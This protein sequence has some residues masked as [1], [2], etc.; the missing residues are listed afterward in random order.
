MA[1]DIF[2]HRAA[3][4]LLPV[5]SLPGRF[6]IGDFGP[7]AK[8]FAR[9][10]SQ[11]RQR[12]WQILPLNPTEPGK[13]HS[14]YSAISSMAGNTLLISP[15]ELVA[16]GLLTKA[17][18]AK[19]TLPSTSTIKYKETGN[20]KNILFER[21]YTAFAG[22]NNEALQNAFRQFVNSTPWLHDFALYSVLRQHHREKPWYTWSEPFKLRDEQALAQFAYD[23]ERAMDKVKWLQFIF[24]RQWTALK[25][26]CNDLGIYLFGDLPFY[27]S[28]DSADVWAYPD[29]FSVDK[30]GAM[31]GM[32]GV[33]PDYFNKNG[34]LW[35]MPV[36]RWDALRKQNYSW[37]IERIRNNRIL[38]DALRL[39]HFRAFSSYWEVPAGN[40]TAVKG[41]WQK[42]PGTDLF[43][44]LHE[45]LG[46]L[47][48]V[49]EDLGDVD[50]DVYKLRDELQLPGMKVLQFAFG[51]DMPTNTH[52]L[53]N[54]TANNL[55][56]TGTHDNNTTRGWYRQN[57]SAQERKSL[58]EYTGQHVT[59]RNVHT[60]LSRMAY[61]SVA[62]IVIL[63]LQDLLGLT[64]KGRIN[65]P[66]TSSHNWEWRMHPKAFT[67]AL[68]KQLKQWTIQYGRDV[69]PEKARPDQDKRRRRNTGTP[70]ATINTPETIT[71]Q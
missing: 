2:S 7:E 20:N 40:K 3:G 52:S 32:A 25:Q 15:E 50:D 11:S 57:T 8:T 14:P 29:I 51:K 21:A 18:I 60:I 62:N 35:G 59:E 33:P 53:H 10:L 17:E 4:I 37:W 61:A 9:L 16:D 65:T 34:Q 63:P 44:A 43:N 55:V 41:Q 70:A 64:E 22:G 5:P 54:H 47:P 69:V 12:F 49:A 42:G 31:I 27:I 28:Y 45:A 6:G 46:P 39:D 48:F 36:F 26:Y 19:Y 30:Q 67:P 24:R 68:Q 56:Y 23:N 58:S 38:Y 1:A 66:S 13:D 71:A